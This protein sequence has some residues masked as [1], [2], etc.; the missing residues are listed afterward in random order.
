MSDQN[1]VSISQAAKMVGITRATLYKHSK[2]KKIT[3]LDQGTNQPKVE[4]SELIRVYGNKVKTPEMRM[5]E[6]EKEK[7]LS[8]PSNSVIIKEMELQTLRTEIR[9]LQ[10]LH[11]A[12]QKA[13]VEKSEQ[14]NQQ[15][16][17]L[18]RQLER[19]TVLLTDQ[20]TEKDKQGDRLVAV[21]RENAA[22]KGAGLFTRLFGFTRKSV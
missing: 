6:E 2:T 20:R 3:I 11:Q 17:F 12:E 8:D 13:A 22:M 21:E 7:F 9:H 4:V 18:Q 5:E 14:Q 15:I 1:I 10:E 16:E 19:T